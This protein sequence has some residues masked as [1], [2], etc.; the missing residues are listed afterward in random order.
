MPTTTAVQP[1]NAPHLLNHP[2]LL[3]AHL[4]PFISPGA[5]AEHGGPSFPRYPPRRSPSFHAVLSSH[6]LRKTRYSATVLDCL[7]FTDLLDALPTGLTSHWLNRSCQDADRSGA[8]ECAG[9]HD[10]RSCLP[11][12]YAPSR[13]SRL[14]A[15][16]KTWSLTLDHAVIVV[17]LRTF[18]RF[19]LIRNSGWDDYTILVALLFTIGYLAE[20]MLIKNESLGFPMGTLTLD[21]MTN[22]L[23]VRGRFVCSPRENAR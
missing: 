10:R 11:L 14:P 1:P 12:Q 23:K 16:L 7:L 5:S 6:W 4:Q 9:H 3:R 22:I 21:N 13:L 15:L 20:I 19:V 8:A 17:G 18:I 2:P